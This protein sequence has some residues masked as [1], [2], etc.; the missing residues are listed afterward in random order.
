[1]A[2][3]GYEVVPARTGCPRFVGTGCNTVGWWPLG[4]LLAACLAGCQQGRTDV[5]YAP[6]NVDSTRVA[7]PRS[8]GGLGD[9]GSTLSPG[10]TPAVDNRIRPPGAEGPRQYDSAGQAVYKIG[11]HGIE[12]DECDGLCMEGDFLTLGC[13]V[14]VA[15]LNMVPDV[16]CCAIRAADNGI[17]CFGD[18]PAADPPEG[19]FK[20][21]DV[22]AFG[23]AINMD[24]ELVFWHTEPPS[25]FQWRDPPVEGPFNGLAVH[26]QFGC[27]LSQ[28]RAYCFGHRESTVPHP[29]D[30]FNAGRNMHLAMDPPTD[31]DG[32]FLAVGAA[33][34][35]LIREDNRLRC[36]G[37]GDEVP[38]S[39]EKPL[40]DPQCD[41]NKGTYACGQALVPITKGVVDVAVGSRPIRLQSD[42]PGYTCVI[43]EDREFVCWGVPIQVTAPKQRISRILGVGPGVLLVLGDGSTEFRGYEV[44]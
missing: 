12:S 6:R 1:M 42:Q 3:I 8:D 38:V 40:T 28:G 18:G 41:L 13:G 26:M 44:W 17:E 27:A 39:P 14:P 7:A 35:C 25:G 32:V 16:R 37:V 30:N 34:A 19:E 31:R 2:S 4:L 43:T 36:W 9:S 33:H 24:D 11:V 10:I 23:A 22:G 20:E 29:G 5:P 21:V 15:I